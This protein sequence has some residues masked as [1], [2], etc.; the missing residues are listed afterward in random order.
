MTRILIAVVTCRRF[1]ARADVQRRTWVPRVIGA[2]VRFFVGAGEGE[3]LPD[4][5]EFDVDDG[6]QGL[7]Q[8]VQ[9][10]FR[11][12]VDQGYDH[13]LKLDD[14]VYV[15]A[16]RLMKFFNPTCD[17]RGRVRAPSRENDAPRLYGPRESEFCSGYAYWVSARAANIVSAMPANGDWAEDR[18]CGNV[19]AK[20]GIRA[21]HDP[22]LKLWPPLSGHRCSL[23]NR[24][25]LA[26]IR[27]YDDA[28][29]VCAYDRPT[30][31]ERIHEYHVNWDFIPTCLPPQ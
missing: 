26:C 15:V 25:C 31:V 1:R 29:V 6:Y 23:P 18:F 11:W 17:Y 16:E 10:A 20:A 24:A 22:T 12:A 7:P 8:K 4:E 9:R 21:V 27:Q 13:I 19:L 28:T 5:V 30:A 2:E 14:D 3:L